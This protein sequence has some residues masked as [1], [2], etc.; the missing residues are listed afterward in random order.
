MGELVVAHLLRRAVLFDEV[1]R[2]LADVGER[3]YRKRLVRGDRISG[4]RAVPAVLEDPLAHALVPVSGGCEDSALERKRIGIELED[5]Q[6]RKDVLR[7]VKELIVKDAR[8]RTRGP[9]LT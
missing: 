2:L 4:K 3:S 6:V 1:G 8:R 7:R 9:C 5:G